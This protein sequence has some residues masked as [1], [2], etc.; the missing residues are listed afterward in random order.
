MQFTL[1]A[2]VAL[3]A[4]ANGANDN[5]KGVATL[6][7][8]GR[9][10]YHRAL[11]WATVFTFLGSLA[12]A[13]FAQGL[14]PK[15]NGTALVGA[16]LSHQSSFLAAVVFG[17]GATVLLASRL[18]L[19][20]S[21]THALTGALAGAGL[22]GAGFSQVH[23]VPLVRGVVVPLIFSPV[24][25]LALTLLVAPLAVRLGAGNDCICVAPASS[26][27]VATTDAGALPVGV[28]LPRIYTGTNAACAV[29]GP[30]SRWSISNGLHWLSGAAVSFSRGLNDTPK[31]AA[32]LFLVSLSPA[33]HNANFWLVGV[34][35]ALGGIGGAARVART[36]SRE[37][38]P[39]PAGDATGANLVAAA[40]VGAASFV[41]LPVS[42]THV[43]SGAIIGLGLRRH[44]ETDWRRV[45]GILFAW[46]G[47]LP[48]GALLGAMCYFLLAPR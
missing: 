4:L 10:T 21:T 7:G 30:A 18:G 45:R 3:L 32:A 20:I 47:T 6:W 28:N 12:A 29:H 46:L 26:V 19:P 33:L 43:T 17:A 38:T 40:L 27:S 48:M 16:T 5:F 35:I 8:S 11:A 15:F 22:L 23:W 44:K 42:T 37:I 31:I 36:M 39:M 25:A 9:A 41:A 2:G 34:A 1:L 24:L 13:W 14:L